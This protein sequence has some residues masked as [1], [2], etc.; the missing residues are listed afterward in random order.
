MESLLNLLKILTE[1]DIDFVIIGGFAAMIYGSSQVTQDIDLCIAMNPENIEKF[2]K[3]LGPYHPV[4]RMTPQKL[5][6]LKHPEELK[7][8]KNLYVKTDLGVLD[9]LGELP[10]VGSY[11]EIASR[12]IDTEFL[13]HKV[14]LVSIDDLIKSKKIVGR[15]KDHATVLEL[16]VIRER[17]KK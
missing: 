1:S 8:I 9:I 12:A 10:G 16:N 2:R 14:K 4:H 15:P 6:F 17:L 7:G 3:T 5:S 11:S 13:G